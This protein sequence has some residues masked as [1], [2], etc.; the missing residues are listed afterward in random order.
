MRH[1]LN[2]AVLIGMLVFPA[3]SAPML[4]FQG[5]SNASAAVRI[6]ED[7]FLVGCDERNELLLYRYE[8]KRPLAEFETSPWLNLTTRN[9][10]VDFEGAA[11]LG[12]VAFWL[13]SH[14]R[15]G[16]GE[17]RPDRQRLLAIRLREEQGK[18]SLEPVGKP[19]TD[20]LHQLSTTPALERYQLDRAS[21][22]APE[23]PGGL[24]FEGLAEGPHESLLLGLRSPLY[25]E[26]ALVIPLQ[27]PLETVQG[28]PARFGAPRLLDLDGQGIRDLLWTGREYY[29]IGGSPHSGGKNTLYRWKGGEAEPRPLKVHLPKNLNPEALVLFETEGRRRLLLLSDD[30]SRGLN[31]DGGKSPR[32]FR[33]FWV[34]L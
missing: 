24:N 11:R 28:K 14:S 30:G 13:G 17:Y 6:G 9:G 23:K 8:D 29:I 3:C 15:N 34:E 18:L 31:H 20:L 33:A 19:V 26:R 7:R 12:D 16:S 1:A 10:E 5:L 2:L 22:I 27:N 32:T 25:E 4:E 21:L